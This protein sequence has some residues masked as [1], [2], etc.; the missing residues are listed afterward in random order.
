MG[1]SSSCLPCVSD[2][3]LQSPRVP[4]FT[5]QKCLDIDTSAPPDF[6]VT[7]GRRTMIPVHRKLLK[8]SS[9]YF[10]CMFECGIQEAQT[11]KLEVKNTPASVVRT[12]ISYM[13]GRNISIEWDDVM[14]YIDLIEMWQMYELKNKLEDYI[15]IN[16]D[17]NNWIHWLFIAQ[18][19]HMHKLA[20]K[21]Q[22][23]ATQNLLDA[24]AKLQACIHT[25]LKNKTTM[26]C[27]YKDALHC[28]GLTKCSAEFMGIVLNIY[29]DTLSDNKRVQVKPSVSML[30]QMC[31]TNN[32]AM[33]S[34]LYTAP[35]PEDL[36]DKD[37]AVIV[38]CNRHHREEDFWDGHTV[39]AMGKPSG[40]SDETV[41]VID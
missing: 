33:D 37:L 24:P 38:G 15:V 1:L 3:N 6:L 39:I 26:D 35:E 11:G 8:A 31:S 20:R 41:I 32:L 5:T 21:S 29:N 16:I 18:I 7:V 12:M 23:T 36:M 30:S 4:A 2:P 22:L 25:V 19:Y 10:H 13:Y 9:H 14:D 17:T 40:R 27:Y 28:L 34:D